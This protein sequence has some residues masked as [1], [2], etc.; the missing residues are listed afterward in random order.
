MTTPWPAS[1]TPYVVPQGNFLQSL[2]IGVDW[3]T[4]PPGTNVTQQQKTAA[5]ADVCMI[6]TAQVNGE[7][8]F[9][10]HALQNTEQLQGPN[11]RVTVHNSTKEG[12]VILSRWPVTSIQQVQVAPAGAYPLQWTTVPAGFYRVEYPVIGHYNS[13]RRAGPVRAGRR[14]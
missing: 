8:N 3:S 9:P 12:R 1:G 6:A 7:V 10:L 14:S 4:L 5:L 2:P 13:T 11:Y